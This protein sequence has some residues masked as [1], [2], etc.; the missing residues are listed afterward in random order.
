MSA[1]RALLEEIIDYAGLF[2]PSA[3]EPETAFGN[4]EFYRRHPMKWMLG[5]FVLPLHM[6]E[7]PDL[8][9]RITVVAKGDDVLLPPLPPRVE[10]I[11]LAGRLMG[12]NQGRLVFQEIGWRGDFESRMPDSGAV[13]LRTG[14]ATAEAVPPAET[15]ARFLI[16][17]A[18][19][20]LPI[21]F[22]AGLHVPVP[23]DDPI[24]GTRHHGFLNVFAAAFA[25][26][27]GCG[28]VNRLASLIQD[29]GY[30]D[31]QLTQD[32]FRAGDFRFSAAG[33]RAL[34]RDR[35]ISFGSCSFLE[36]VEHL[37]RHGYLQPES[38]EP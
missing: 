10:S 19:R 38:V 29:A 18:G 32:E 23:N 20:G 11:E 4:D 25:V 26:Y 22:T 1:I 17:A 7:R 9:P 35:V 14:G 36:P 28:D 5:R 27:T 34:R 12:S 37:K 30:E 33:I 8:P 24:S 31:F 3:L 13:K 6:V 2:P 16:A 21:K 15:V